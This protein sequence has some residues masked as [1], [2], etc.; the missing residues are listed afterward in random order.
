M[1]STYIGSSESI[2]PSNL[3]DNIRDS[4]L[5]V[6]KEKG[7]SQEGIHAVNMLAKEYYRQFQQSLFYWDELKPL[8]TDA[9]ECDHHCAYNLVNDDELT[10]SVHVMPKGT[11]IPMQAYPG[12]F[13]LIMV[14][15]GTLNVEQS[16]L[17]KQWMVNSVK[18]NKLL[19]RGDTC[20]GL[21]VRNNMHQLKAISDV[22]VFIS[23]RISSQEKETSNIISRLFSKRSLVLA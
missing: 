7:E 16:S 19:N 3:V 4:L 8:I 13:S 9:A 10:L 5:N 21:P 2:V 1:S 14:E 20:V 15:Y 12:K 22:A 11:E 17:G 18:D 23:L 6:Y